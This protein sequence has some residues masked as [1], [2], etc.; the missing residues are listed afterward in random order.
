MIGTYFVN[1]SLLLIP[2]QILFV[3]KNLPDLLC[4]LAIVSLLCLR[5]IQSLM[6]PV[7]T[8][9]IS[10]CICHRGSHRTNG[11]ILNFIL[12][13]LL[14]QILFGLNHKFDTPYKPGLSCRLSGDI[15][16]CILSIHS[17]VCLLSRKYRRV[18]QV[19][20]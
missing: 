7:M 15:Y 19:T 1:A 16:G 18:I 13:T 3:A 10:D 2:I 8:Y 5:D 12:R 9:L 6:A 4:V 14:E 17:P 20:N 11:Q